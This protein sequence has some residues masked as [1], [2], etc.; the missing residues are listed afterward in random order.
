MKTFLVL[1]ST[2]CL[3]GCQARLHF[4]VGSNPWPASPAMTYGDKWRCVSDDYKK[5]WDA[6]LEND[7][8]WCY[9]EDQ[10]K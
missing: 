8:Y 3:V 4:H 9:V 6:R 10:I 7:A 2:S 1:L 5:T